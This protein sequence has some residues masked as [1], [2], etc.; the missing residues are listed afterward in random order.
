MKKLQAKLEKV[1]KKHTGTEDSTLKR[2]IGDSAAEKFR[3]TFEARH[4]VG[5]YL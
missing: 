1:G 5:N 3:I 2:T 4:I